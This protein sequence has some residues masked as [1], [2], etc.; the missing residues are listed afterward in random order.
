[1]LNAQFKHGLSELRERNGLT[2]QLLF[3]GQ[4]LLGGAKYCVFS[5]VNA[6]GYTVF[7]NCLRHHCKVPFHALSA[8]KGTAS[9]DPACVVSIAA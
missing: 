6:K 8:S 1:M 3:Y 2:A 9:H 7:P 4:P 5:A